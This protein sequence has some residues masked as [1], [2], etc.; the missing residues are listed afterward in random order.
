MSNQTDGVATAPFA[1][2]VRWELSG[3]T[4]MRALIGKLCV[5]FF[6]AAGRSF[7]AYRWIDD[8]AVHLGTFPTEPEACAAVEAW[9]KDYLTGES[10]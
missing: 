9:I 2:Q 8:G 10:R 1:V 4:E 6:Y 3:G 7:H 5:G